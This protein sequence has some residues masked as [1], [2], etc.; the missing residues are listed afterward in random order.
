VSE[1]TQSIVFNAIPLFVLAGVYVAVGLASVVSTWRERG[2]LRLLDVT[3]A[4][5]F[6]G[7]AAAA[8]AFGALVVADE[9]PLGGQL[10]VSFTATVVAVLAAPL[11]LSRRERVRA[12]RA[13]AAAAEAGAERELEAVA[14]LSDALARA[15]DPESVARAL[16][17]QVSRRFEVDVAALA[18]VNE[19]ATEATGLLMRIEGEDVD[20]YREVRYDLLN[21][22]S[23]VAS[24]V[25]EAAAFAVHDA[26]RSSRVSQRMV[27]RLGARSVAY[28]PL[29]IKE[30]V[31]AVLVVADT[32]RRRTFASDE[33]LLMQALASEAAMALERAQSAAALGSALDRERLVARI[34]RKVRSELDLDAVL[35][36][37]V[38]E[39]A[40]ALGLQRCF[41]RLGEPG[42]HRP[43]A[44]E[45]HAP[46]VDPLVSADRLPVSN[47]AVRRRR[48]V[49]VADVRSSIELDDESLGGRESL[50]GVGVL[51]VL[52][53]PIVVFDE[54]IGVLGLHRDVVH[55]WTDGELALAEAVAREVGL[56][57]HTG[58]LLEE[59]ERRIEQHASLLKAAQALT[60]ELEVE[61]VL[62]GLVDRVA[63]LLRVESADCYLLDRE[64]HTFRCAAVHGIAAELVGYEF[65]A[66]KGAAGEALRRGRP[67]IVSDYERF[68]NPVPHAAY[69]G[70]TDVL[71]APMVWSGE[72]QGVLGVGAKGGARTFQSEDADLL[73]AFAGLA[74]LALRNA[75]SFAARS[76]QARVQRGFYRI[77]SVLGESLSLGATLDAVAQAAV[78]AFGGAFGAVFMTRGERLELSGAFGLSDD[79]RARLAGGPPDGADVLAT[80]SSERRVI[81][82]PSVEED[83]RFDEPFRELAQSAGFA[84]L[85]AVPIEAPRNESGGLVVVFV[86]TDRRFTDDDLELARHLAGATRG[87]LERSEL[88]EAERTARALAQQLARTGSLLATELDPDA[89]L[90]EVVGHAPA[91][92]GADACVIRTLEGDE[93]VVRAAEGEG[94]G[95]ATE[96]RSPAT[97][98]LSGDVV[99]SRAPVPIDDA[100]GDAR[101]A[102][103]DPLLAAGYRAYLG[104]PLVGPEGALHG[105]LAVY[106]KRA[107]RW[108]EEEIEALIALAGNTSAA[109]SNAELY[110]RVADEQERSSAILRNIAD[111]IVAVDRD[112]KVVLW[113]RAAEQITGVPASEAVSRVP[114]E[115]LR[116]PLDSGEDV[117]PGVNRLVSIL[118]GGEEV[119]LSLSEAVMRDP[120]GAVAGRIYAFRDISADRLVEEMKS[121]FVSAVS[122]ELRTPLTSIYGFAETLLRQDVL[123][124]EEERRT[125]LGY[126]ASESERLT[127]IVDQLLNVAR[128]D[129]GDL[130][131]NLAPVDVRSVVAEVVDGARQTDV[132]GHRF[133][134]EIPDEP[135]EAVADQEKLRQILGELVDNAVKY[136]PDGGTVTIGA[137]RASDKVEVRV[138]DQGLGIPASEQPRIF[139][140]FYRADTGS[141][142][143]SAAGTG[144]GLFIAEGLVK[145]MNGRIWVTSAEG[146]GSS[147]SFELPLAQ[148][149]TTGDRE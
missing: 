92:L 77:A 83:D 141:R 132:D 93:L 74:S 87:A 51:A 119:W 25:F 127:A 134:L 121:G 110:Q 11:S 106:D 14:T 12:E 117:P 72:P 81:A 60:G 20:W 148:A 47:L 8:A 17:D 137:R 40:R 133:V 147:F 18:L 58:R 109:L 146:E 41:V 122:H 55:E 30:R 15:A 129:S 85:L 49:A 80:A 94:T 65:P 103:L 130:Q 90:D 111:G 35:R 115:V 114:V 61:G 99:Q 91:L 9:R 104:V 113:N 73:E 100:A 4:V 76:R 120:T 116:R 135:L 52:A 140:K 46:H 75:E 29:I 102:A 45:W 124:G 63:E 78:E 123:F 43:V 88:F 50:L 28:V 71:V 108:R 138:D 27:G 67:V 37:A 144:L 59:T 2:V 101:L 32:R 34:S 86:E 48:T 105:V 96:S 97:G 107:R 142:E 26:Q 21:E 82:S 6:A 3:P 112:G 7:V 69:S 125:F 79:L 98:W 31:A 145:A 128:L 62:Q 143:G 131:V 126:I 149:A 22:P 1:A 139:R 5:A 33:L 95:A 56:A 136:S 68:A 39:T 64:R 57:I 16:L 44:A 70:F 118:R 24:A 89:V 23:G 42:G 53:T 10:W 38:Q 36:V 66:D 54:L 13:R 19:D 84:S